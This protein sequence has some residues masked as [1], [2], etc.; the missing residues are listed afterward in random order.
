M[1]N[2]VAV[3]GYK[4][5]E[6][7]DGTRPAVHVVFLD[8]EPTAERAGVNGALLAA[9]EARLAELDARERQYRRI[10]VTHLVDDP[11]ARVWTYVGA[12]AGRARVRDDVPK[13]IPR[14]YLDLVEAAFA[15]RGD[16]EAYRATTEP[17]PFPVTELA[18]ID[19]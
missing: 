16:L 2:R 18:R 11:P 15:R 3:P 17:P 13:A 5:Y 8:L 4:V 14:A 10:D 9:D 19:L 6:S 1:D 12:P 7:P